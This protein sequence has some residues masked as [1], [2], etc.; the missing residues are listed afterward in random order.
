VAGVIAA[1]AKVVPVP[2]FC[3]ILTSRNQGLAMG[4]PTIFKKGALT[5]AERQKRHRAK[6]RRQEHALGKQAFIE[7]KRKRL[8]ALGQGYI[9]A[10]PGITYWRR[11]TVI[12]P[13]GERKVYAPVTQPLASIA[14]AELRDVDIA[15]LIH[16]LQREQRV[17][18]GE[19][20][21]VLGT[22]L[23]L[24]QMTRAINPPPDAGVYIGP[25][26]PP[27]LYEEPNAPDYSE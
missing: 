12:T 11:M 8:A 24:R 17:R 6:I 25:Y 1:V 3:D 21:R 15:A 10:P 23:S 7:D 13:Q 20:T 27:E 22:S 19:E 16:V 9:P 5:P 18:A 2:W 4:R 14:T 26:V